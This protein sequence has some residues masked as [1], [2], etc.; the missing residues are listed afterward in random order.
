M[1]AH[2][3]I[4][5]VQ[6]IGIEIAVEELVRCYVGGACGI[7]VAVESHHHFLG[8]IVHGFHHVGVGIGVGAHV[9]KQRPSRGFHQL[10]VFGRICNLVGAIFIDDIFLFYIFLFININNIIAP[11]GL[12]IFL[13]ILHVFHFSFGW[14]MPDGSV[15]SQQVLHVMKG[16]IVLPY[17]SESLAAN[18]NFDEIAFAVEFESFCNVV[19]HVAGV[20]LFQ[21]HPCRFAQIEHQHLAYLS[22]GEPGSRPGGDEL[23]LGDD[24]DAGG[25]RLDSE[26][27]SI[28]SRVICH[29]ISDFF[30]LNLLK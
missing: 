20:H 28:A 12:H 22:V 30:V 6:Q 25:E 9:G 27:A 4:A 5:V 14:L 15:E 19:E 2:H 3:A 11:T 17:K 23:A 7:R 18:Q 1:D 29:Y 21:V 16:C 10:S 26:V 8:S 13:R 24:V